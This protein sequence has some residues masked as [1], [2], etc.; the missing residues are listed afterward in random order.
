MSYAQ[1][2]YGNLG[3]ASWNGS[4][5]QIE[6]VDTGVWVMHIACPGQFRSS[7]YRLL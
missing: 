5:W 4:A 7:A 1:G 6:T 2:G 3:Y